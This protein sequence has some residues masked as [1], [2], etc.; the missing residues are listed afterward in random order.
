MARSS[1]ERNVRGG[2]AHGM[3]PREFEPKVLRRGLLVELEHTDDRAVAERI[4]MDHI[5][6]TGHQN[7]RGLWTSSYY[8]DLAKME[9][10]MLRP[11]RSSR[12]KVYDTEE[13]A[14]GIRER[15]TDRESEYEHD[16]SFSWPTEM[17]FV[18]Y[19]LA[20]AY[21]SDKWQKKN[22]GTGRRKVELY[23]HIAESQNYFFCAPGAIEMDD[24]TGRVALIGPTVRW[25]QDYPPM[26]DSFAILGLFKEANVQLFTD[27]DD[28][29]PEVGEGEDDGV[30]TLT[31]RHGVLGGS[32]IPWSRVSS[33]RDEP[34]LFVYTA[35]DGIMFVILGDKLDILKDGI[36][37]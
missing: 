1:A 27:G 22:P 19:S 7:E 12:V 9:K 36:V 28:E 25:Q 24:G 16:F 15:F 26:P 11:N 4:A 35:A 2:Y 33:R 5:V 6:E 17:Q 8:A 29:E 3:S 10:G 13:L 21:G 20:V 18:G 23:K 31:V 32:V 14:R 30:V 34:F 37:G